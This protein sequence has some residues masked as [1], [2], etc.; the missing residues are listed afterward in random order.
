MQTTE[1]W[2]RNVTDLINQLREFYLNLAQA[3]ISHADKIEEL[4]E[5]IKK[6]EKQVEEI[7]IQARGQK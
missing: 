1:H 4:E 2:M 7:Q 5:R 6:L 3:S